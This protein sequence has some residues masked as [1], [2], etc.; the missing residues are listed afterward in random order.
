M[1]LCL[2]IWSMLVSVM[3]IRYMG[4][5]VRQRLVQVQMA[6]CAG[7]HLRMGVVV[8]SII[9]AVRV[10]VLHGLVLVFVAVRLGQVQ[11]HAQRHQ[12]SAHR[13]SPAAAAV[14]QCNGQSR[15]NKRRKCKH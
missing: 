10:F 5:Q 8:V 3:H 12:G 13:H 14:A 11:H 1:D 9:M 2:L 15:P 4:V 7:R 6:V